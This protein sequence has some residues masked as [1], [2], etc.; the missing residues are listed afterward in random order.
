MTVSLISRLE[1]IRSEHGLWSAHNLML[2]NGVFTISSQ[3]S[4]RVQRRSE[5]Y[6]GFS[7]TL[8]RRRI[9][10]MRVLDLG[11]LEGGVSLTLASKGATCVGVDVRKQHLA[12]AD[13]AARELGLSR[14]C[15]WV[16][17]DV[18]SDQIWRELGKYDIIICSG[19][20]YH[21]DAKS[22]LPLLVNI[23]EACKSWESIVFVD[24]NIAT[25]ARDDFA[26][27][28][29]LVLRGQNYKE[30]DP[31]ATEDQRLSSGWSS[32]RNDV[33][34]WLTERSLVNAMVAAGFGNVFKPM[35]PYHE[36]RHQARDIWIGLPNPSDPSGLPLRDD[37]DPRP[38]SHPGLIC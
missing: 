24:T 25:E 3:A 38:L 17:G 11:C 22:I 15:R 20:L 14:R 29:G 28:K 8:L 33:S 32:Y 23:R 5:L 37:P 4:D 21:L 19:L 16:L 31:E 13:F 18:T 27:R 2:A 1:A 30:F 6:V 9:R 12:K 10:G 35:Y 36:W 34:F 26:V 7:K